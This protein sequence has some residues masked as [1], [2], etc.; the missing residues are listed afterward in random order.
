M[1]AGGGLGVRSEMAGNPFHNQADDLLVGQHVRVRTRELVYEGWLQIREYNDA[2]VVL[3]DA[4]REFTPEGA[5]EDTG[6]VGDVVVHDIEA[7]ERAESATPIER[8]PLE[9]LD[10]S[11]YTQRSFDDQDFRTYVRTVRERGH[12][13]SFPLARPI[14]GTRQPSGGRKAE[15]ELVSGHRRTEAARQAGLEAIPVRVRELSDWEA[16]RVFLDKHVPAT[17]E[18]AQQAA[19]PDSH[20]GFYTQETLEAVLDDLREDWDDQRLY[21]HPAMAWYLDAKAP[22]GGRNGAGETIATDT[23]EASSPEDGESS[24]RLPAGRGGESCDRRDVDAG[25]VT[26]LI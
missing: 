1:Q 19:D 13:L 8:V 6:R 14:G 20:S 17:P 24:E 25:V 18:E 9:A 10:R 12:L 15:Y 22:F 23:E 4:T 7:I 11:P 2:A 16:T 26:L 21:E 5:Q 3:R